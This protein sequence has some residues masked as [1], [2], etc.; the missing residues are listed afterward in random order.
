MARP[1]SIVTWWRRWAAKRLMPVPDAG[2]AWC[3]GCTLNGG[4]TVIVSAAGYQV[5]AEEHRELYEHGGSDHTIEMVVT[6]PV[7]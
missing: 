3:I 5:H 4:R 2:E 1:D 7:S 6:W